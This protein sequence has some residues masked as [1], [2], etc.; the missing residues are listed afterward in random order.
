MWLSGAC[1]VELLP[2]THDVSRERSRWKTLSPEV[3]RP[4]F[5]VNIRAGH[6]R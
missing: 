3:G 5:A 6:V 1:C 2:N 4:G